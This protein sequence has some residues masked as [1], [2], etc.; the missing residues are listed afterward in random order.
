VDPEKEAECRDILDESV[1]QHRYDPHSGA[2][3]GGDW[4]AEWYDPSDMDALSGAVDEYGN[5]THV[6]AGGSQWDQYGNSIYGTP[7]ADSGIVDGDATSGSQ[8]TA[9]TY[10]G[11][12]DAY[13]KMFGELF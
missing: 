10:P 3:G 4:G 8:Y 5:P 7:G 9:D 6:A 13:N 2:Q 11:G 12:A 1:K